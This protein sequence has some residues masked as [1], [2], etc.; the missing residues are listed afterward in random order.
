MISLI[1]SLIIL[2]IK[3]NLTAINYDILIPRPRDAYFSINKNSI[4]LE[5]GMFKINK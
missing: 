2:I 3:P 4:K 5:K 1:S